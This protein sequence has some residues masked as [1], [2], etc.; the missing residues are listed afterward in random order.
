[1]MGAAFFQTAHGALVAQGVGTISNP[2]PL[3]SNLGLKFPYLGLK[4]PN[5]GLKIAKAGSL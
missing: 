5:L 4:V 2:K 3:L 1:M